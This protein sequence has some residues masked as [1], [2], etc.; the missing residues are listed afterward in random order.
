[1]ST[2]VRVLVTTASLLS[3]SNAT[4]A[5]ILSPL[6]DVSSRLLEPNSAIQ[7]SSGFYFGGRSRISVLDDT[8]FVTGGSNAS[9]D[10]EIGFS[11]GVA[12][13]YA[14]VPQNSIIGGRIELEANYFDTSVDQLTI[15]GVT[16]AD[17]DSTGSLS[18]ITGYASGYVDLNLGN[19]QRYSGTVIGRLTPFVGAGIGYSDVSF[20]EIGSFTDGLLINDST[21]AP[22]YHLS[23]GVAVALR[24]KT[25]IEFGYR[26]EEIIEA[27]FE[28]LDGTTS[29]QD[30]ARQSFTFGLRRRF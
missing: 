7:P 6:S 12:L 9:V 27:E 2:K 3:V 4:A 18:A 8:S 24:E 14:F 25:S 16:R 21:G 13:G 30:I 28:A 29:V 10:Y 23:V 20:N 17:E 22:A 1:M 15:N 19:T 5:D 26:Y 11:G